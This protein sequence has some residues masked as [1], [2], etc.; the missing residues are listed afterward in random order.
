[1]TIEEFWDK[2]INEDI[3]DIF[4]E[5]CDF[6]SQELPQE[7]LEEYDAIEVILET[8]GHQQTAKNFDNVVKFIDIIKKYQPELYKE[9]FVYLNDFL[10]DY[11]SFHQNRSKVDEAFS[12]FIDNPLSDYDNYLQA[13]RTILFYQHSELLNRA[14]VENYQAV[15]TSNSIL[16]GAYDLAIS[17]FYII[18]Q[19]A[20]ENNNK[21]LD[22][23]DFIS[24]LEKFDFELDEGVFS[25]VQK[26]LTQFQLNIDE[27]NNLF[28]KDRLCALMLLRGFF[29]RYMHE[30]GFEFY[31]SGHIWDKMLNYWEGKNKKAKKLDFYINVTTDSF[32]KYLTDFSSM[33]IDNKPEMIATLWGSVYIYEFLDK[34]GIISTEVY[35]GFLKTTQKLKG[36]IIGRYTPDLWTSN[37]IHHWQ[38]PDSVS[39]T[40]FNEEHKIFTKS[41]AFKYDYFSVARE[42]ISEELANIGELADYI[43]EGGESMTGY[44]DFNILE[45]LLKDSAKRHDE[46]DEEREYIP[47]E[48]KHL[49]PVRTEP[50][51][52][53]N[54]PCPCGSGKKYKKC[55]GKG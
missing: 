55:C 25:A 21:E 3:L 53:R 22:K 11:Y 12:L 54:D 26:G 39:E 15:S 7:F 37:F 5:T 16:G 1:M 6:F 10:V 17:M 41:I 18:L 4:D 14:I 30:R 48:E 50:K 27:L 8:S 42:V 44:N 29:L 38:K 40:E 19:E 9:S 49:E 33:F 32:E 46:Y 47:Y 45:N 24:K 36:K 20:F 34:L 31:L 13:Y 2:Y 52:G 23:N 28:D 43:I 35:Q 51:V